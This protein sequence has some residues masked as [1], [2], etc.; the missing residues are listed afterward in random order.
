MGPRRYSLHDHKREQRADHLAQECNSWF[1]GST[2]GDLVDAGFVGA[3][4]RCRAPSCF[5]RSE[6][7]PLDRYGLKAR[8]YNLRWLYVCSE[9]GTKGP[10][11]HPIWGA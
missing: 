9:C 4:W 5:H 6:E 1:G 3:E 8:P 2:I 10:K 7:F 11:L